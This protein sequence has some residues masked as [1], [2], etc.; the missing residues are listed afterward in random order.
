MNFIFSNK[1]REYTAA[2]IIIVIGF[3]LR[4]YASS[5]V[6]LIFDEHEK[7]AFIHEI[8]F[9]Y[10][11]LSLP[12]GSEVTHNPPFLPYLI[13]LSTLIMG[14]NNLAL[15]LPSVILGTLTLLIIFLL[16]REN[17]NQKTA[18]L[19]LTLMSLSQF[20][21]GSTR[22]AWEEGLLLF[23]ASCTLLFTQ[24]AINTPRKSFLWLTAVFMGIGLFV[25]GTMITLLPVIVFYIFF[26]TPHKKNLSKKGS[27]YF[28]SHHYFH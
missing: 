5:S 1:K 20:C 7:I 9:D 23:F 13:K 21:I 25:K 2:F 4:L 26:Y 16:V 12:L 17:L 8:H 10:K 15:R 27:V 24:K 6:P 11:N 22:I 19:V 28:R 3:A 18:M 14:E